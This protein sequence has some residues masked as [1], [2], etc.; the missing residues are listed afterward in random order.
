MKNVIKKQ[1][2]RV[3][4]RVAKTD[5]PELTPVAQGAAAKASPGV[6][7]VRVDG[8]VQALEVTCRCGDVSVIELEYEAE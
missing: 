2:V 6:R 5:H 1:F 3:E 8:Q 4:D 7:V